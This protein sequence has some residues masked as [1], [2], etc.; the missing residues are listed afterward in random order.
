MLIEI[1]MLKN[2]PPTCLNR[3]DTGTPKTCY[4]GGVQRGRISS[5]CLKRSWRT[6]ALF[7]TLRSRGW[8]SR[9]L[10]GMVSKELGD[11]PD[12]AIAHVKKLI[13]DLLKS[14]SKNAAK[15]GNG[16]KATSSANRGKKKEGITGQVVFFTSDE[17]RFLAD[18][19]HSLW[20]KEAGESVEKFLEIKTDNIKK[21]VETIKARAIT[22][23][24]ALFGRMVTS[25][26]FVN[27][28]AAMQV[29]HAVSTHALDLE[30]D[31]FAAVDDLLTGQDDARAGMLGDIDFDSC[32]YYQYASL[33]M[34]KL[35]ET[36]KDSPEA[37]ARVDELIPVLLKVMALS[38][39]SGKQNSF[40]GHVAPEVMLV[41]F[42]SDKI[43]LSYVNAFAKPVSRYS[44]QIVKDSA[45]RLAQEV[46]L[47]D[48]FYALPVAHRAWMS[49]RSETAPRVCERF[50]SLADL[51]DACAAWARE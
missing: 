35:R 23:D 13:I 51:T 26:A 38:N 5:Q 25:E 21:E 22:L 30:S 16:R 33:D 4:F 32:C 28:E 6:S 46:D 12:K 43:P 9:N 11:M 36:L 1:H 34:D 19:I 8:R 48:D 17:A 49:L 44:T 39:P 15:E 18:T 3:D 42:K 40:A 41:E 27:V 45:D 14:D 24:I 10:P 50:G 7:E 31:Y 29:A 37:L 2:Y 20:E 47:M